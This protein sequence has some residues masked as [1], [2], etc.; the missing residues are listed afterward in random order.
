[1]K[2]NQIFFSS[3]SSSSSIPTWMPPTQGAHI[4]GAIFIG[5]GIAA[6]IFNIT[7]M[8]TLSHL[9][10]NIMSHIFYLL[11]FNFAI[12]DLLKSIC[13][14]IW[15]LKMLPAGIS[16]SMFFM[17]ADQF[18]LMILRFA[19]LATIL[20]LLVLTLNEYIYI[21][22]PF[23]YRRF[24]TNMRVT[25]LIVICWIISW[26]F[27]L[28][29]LFV[30]SQKQSIYIKPDCLMKQKYFN[31]SA[32]SNDDFSRAKKQL[33]K[34]YK[35]VIVIGSVLAIYTVYLI[36]YSAIKFLF[37]SRLRSSRMG[38]SLTAMYYI[39]WGFQTLMCLNALLQ[40]LCYF[41]THE[42]RSAFKSVIF[43]S[44][45][46]TTAAEATYLSI[47]ESRRRTVFEN[48]NKMIKLKRNIQCLELHNF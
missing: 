26:G 47:S 40:P 44:N 34:R 5:C 43:C 42:F 12:I 27:T 14:V 41:R 25:I 30:G 6:I 20:N 17:K 33:L 18:A 8:I 38:I 13:S 19:N 2:K 10:R 15:A 21:I 16:T 3:S 9:R 31:D 7:V 1:M 32:N 37:V 28:S 29:I 35:Y 11:I 23:H 46:G 36:S 39:R 45:C 24:V 48:S 22:Y 4:F